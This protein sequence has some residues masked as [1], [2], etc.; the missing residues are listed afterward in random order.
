MTAILTLNDSLKLKIE[1]LATKISEG[2]FYSQK[3]ILK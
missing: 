3:E 2:D 1:F